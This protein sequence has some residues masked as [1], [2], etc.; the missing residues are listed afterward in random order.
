MNRSDWAEPLDS[1]AQV[2]RD[3]CDPRW[4]AAICRLEWVLCVAFEDVLKV[5]DAFESAYGALTDAG[6]LTAEQFEAASNDLERAY[7]AWLAATLNLTE[8]VPDCSP[9]RGMPSRGSV[10]PPY[11]FLQP[12]ERNAG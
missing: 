12:N 9:I 7:D 4:E 2:W 3:N 6:N 5:E 10:K 1:L 8:G 11:L